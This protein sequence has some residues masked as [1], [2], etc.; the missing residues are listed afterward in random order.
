MKKLKGK[1]VIIDDREFD[2]YK[3]KGKKKT[4]TVREYI[5]TDE[6]IMLAEV[7]TQKQELI[8]QMITANALRDDLEWSKL[9]A[10]YDAL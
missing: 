3:V 2:E 10:Q 7:E 5:Q 6:E 4:H 9:K 8:N 1:V